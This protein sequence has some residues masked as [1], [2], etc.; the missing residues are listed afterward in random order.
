MMIS[1]CYFGIA[2]VSTKFQN[3][4]RGRNTHRSR[5][6]STSRV[7]RVARMVLLLVFAFGACWTPF[8]IKNVVQIFNIR[9]GKK[10]CELIDDISSVG[11][12]ANSVLNPI[13]YSFLSTNFRH[14]IKAIAKKFIRTRK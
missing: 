1:V 9:L 13:I 2:Y 3:R 8:Q 12:I 5:G 10:Y 7:D 14:K 4:S 6:Y 11:V